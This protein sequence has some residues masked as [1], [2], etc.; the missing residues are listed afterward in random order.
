LAAAV[1]LLGS[2]CGGDPPTDTVAVARV[3]VSPS[4]TTMK[5]GE[6]RGLSALVYNGKGTVLSVPVSWN[7]SDAA[8][9]TV[10][11]TGLLSALAPGN[12]TVTASAGGKSG[13]VAV[14]VERAR[15]ARVLLAAGAP[16]EVLVGGA[17]TY[18]ANPVD[19][20]G[21]QAVGWT[22]TWSVSDTT[23][24][25]IDNTGALRA[26]GAGSVNVR[27]A[28]D[29]A[30]LTT[31]LRV[32]GSL[33]LR[34]TDLALAQAIQ[35]QAGSIPMI[36]D[37]LPVLLSAWV[38]SDAPL[39]SGAWARASCGDAVGEQ[40]RDSTRL[41]VPLDSTPRVTLPAVQW[42]LPNA[43]MGA[44]LTCHV[45]VDPEARIPDPRRDNNRFPVSGGKSFTVVDVPPLEITFIPIVLGADGGVMGNVT[46]SNVEQ[47]LASA[48]QMLPLGLVTPRVGN[49]YT[50]NVAFGG[51]QDVAW[52]AILREV[53]SKRQL[54][55]YRGHY[56]GVIRP[57]NGITF[58]QFSGFGFI[59]GRSAV[60]VQVGWFNRESAAR[61]TVAHEL[62]HN[63]GRPHAPCGGAASPDPA[64]PHPEAEI[65]VTG[66]DAWTAIL[67][68][69][70]DYQP[71][72]TKDLMS[73]CRPLWISDYNFRKI[74][75][76][77]QAMALARVDAAARSVLVRGEMGASPQ[78]EA[79][80]LVEGADVSDRRPGGTAIAEVLDGSG[81]VVAS[82]PIALLVADHG[83]PPSFVGRVAVSSSANVAVVR[84]RTP[85]GR[86]V[87]R[88]L[89]TAATPPA[90]VS[91]LGADLVRVTWDATRVS[92]V[93]LRDADTGE[94]LTF[95]SGGRAVVRVADKRLRATFSNG[96]TRLVR[97]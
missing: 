66:W 13:Q 51:G 54:D 10:A 11:N 41:V 7:S 86:T 52:R 34:V 36:R 58:V 74:I 61:E 73:Y 38:T 89:A 95:A 39:S 93:I 68:G 81:R 3:D 45:V 96:D 26:I 40:W 55:G 94:V 57:G 35:D 2:A 32:R 27:V 20:E 1:L 37:G 70:G 23:V 62:G 56:Y 30:A 82:G 87:S 22:P 50:T 77:R 72:T 65:G 44:G 21:G 25:R 9:A 90:S 83:G 53:E 33:D 4:A 31:T 88:A 78:L 12:V 17:V 92:D 18:V 15:V 29:T 71:P 42:L 6:V 97:W 64:Y 16:E 80:F 76:G 28:F 5:L 84:V 60:S 63:F 69:R 79:P 91:P 19:I 67:G 47:Y 46:S 43:K 49:P 48:R 24:A 75:E 8:V 59:S 14:T 85:D